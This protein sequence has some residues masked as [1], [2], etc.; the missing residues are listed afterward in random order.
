MTTRDRL[1]EEALNA[2]WKPVLSND[3]ARKLDALVAAVAE[4]VDDMSGTELELPVSYDNI[5]AALAAI[6]TP[7]GE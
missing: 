3:D 1:R 6:T 7:E 5:R 4:F 2:P